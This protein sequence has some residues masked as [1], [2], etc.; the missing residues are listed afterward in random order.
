MKVKSV[1]LIFYIIALLAV[2]AW[3]IYLNKLEEEIK[4]TDYSSYVYY[5]QTGE[6]F[7]P[8]NN[9]SEWTNVCHSQFK[10]SYINLEVIPKEIWPEICK[11]FEQKNVAPI[12]IKYV[13]KKIG[14][15]NPELRHETCN[16][17]NIINQLKIDLPEIRKKEE[18]SK[19]IST[20]LSK[21]LFVNITTGVMWGLLVFGFAIWGL[22]STFKKIE[23][24]PTD[25]FI[26]VGL[27]I[28]GEAMKE[29]IRKKQEEKRK[30]KEKLDKEKTLADLE[31]DIRVAELTKKKVTVEKE[32]EEKT[33]SGVEKKIK[34]RE[35][36]IEELK[37]DQKFD[38]EKMKL[39][40]E[41]SLK[42]GETIQDAWDQERKKAMQKHADDPERL[43][44]E[45]D[46]LDLIFIGIRSKRK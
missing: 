36:E 1:F 17:A 44:K 29:D 15:T 45:L 42:V 34:Q 8:K 35:K 38:A 16:Q 22:I 9:L 23:K 4:G 21:L 25:P 37:I 11:H 20:K 43:K 14:C 28:I 27:G 41:D 6:S 18:K 30:E 46:K 32:I 31:H 10:D 3:D 2:S 39:T 19:E 13:G 33:G 12:E 24:L 5:Y 7:W 40:I 26:E